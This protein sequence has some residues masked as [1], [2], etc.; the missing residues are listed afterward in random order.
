MAPLHATHSYGP[1]TGVDS[2]AW[3]SVPCPVSVQTSLH[4]G[5]LVFV[6]PLVIAL[7]VQYDAA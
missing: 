7:D 4:I 6:L 5:G 1:F 3:R 2:I